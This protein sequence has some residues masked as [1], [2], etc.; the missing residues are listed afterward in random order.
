LFKNVVSLE[1]VIKL[2]VT[3]LCL[4][5]LFLVV[6]ISLIGY[7]STKTPNPE[8]T[9]KDFWS[10]FK[11]GNYE[12]A[13]EFLSDDITV[14][15]LQENLWS[16][17]DQVAADEIITV[18]LERINLTTQGHTLNGKTAVV[19]AIVSW[20]NMELFVGKFMAEAFAVAF[21]AA[22]SGASQDEIDMLLKPVILKSLEE[23][24]DTE[25]PH[26]IHLKLVDGKWKISSLPIPNPKEV[27][28][29]ANFGDTK[30]IDVE[31]AEYSMGQTIIIDSTNLPELFGEA[32][33]SGDLE[34][35]VISVEKSPSVES[36]LYGTVDAEGAFFTVYYSINNTANS[37][38]QPSTQLN[39]VFVLTDINGHRW[40]PAGYLSHSFDVSE[41]FA[42][43]KKHSD[44]KAWVSPGFTR[45]TAV[46]F[47]IPAQAQGLS[48]RSD[49]LGIYVQLNE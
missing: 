39:D 6:V 30:Q 1:G 26:N 45:T 37:R 3:K 49:R 2:N 47:D 28:T 20:P 27:F 14:E 25:T 17:N 13:H 46:S 35:T 21:P 11:E 31:L 15:K 40:E 9:V 48:L 32:K 34:L 16:E 23:T 4:T 18:F 22:L 7:G 24:A 36:P 19:S 29:L 10:A 44:P 42:T 33:T 38:I 5:I 12:K 43:S 8:Q 41:V